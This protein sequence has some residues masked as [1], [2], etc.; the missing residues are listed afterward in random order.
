MAAS[1]GYVFGADV[2]LKCFRHKISNLTPKLRIGTLG[3]KPLCPKDLIGEFPHVAWRRS[4]EPLTF[5]VGK[6]ETQICTK[7]PQHRV[8]FCGSEYDIVGILLHRPNENKMSHRSRERALLATSV[9]SHE[10]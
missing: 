6:A 2:T 1:F 10:K 8:H 5:F 7:L 9:F 4:S 3:L